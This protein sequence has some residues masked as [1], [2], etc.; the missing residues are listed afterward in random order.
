VPTLKAATDLLG[1]LRGVLKLA[2][3]DQPGQLLLCLQELRVDGVSQERAAS[4]FWWEHE[5]E[6][7]AAAEREP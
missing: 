2:L 3:R 5:P 6:D 4:T 7:A 1:A